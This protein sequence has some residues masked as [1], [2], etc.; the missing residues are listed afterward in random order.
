M[1]EVLAYKPRNNAAVIDTIGEA[2][3]D[4]AAIPL[5]NARAKIID[6]HSPAWI[7]KGY[8]K[9][10]AEMQPLMDAGARATADIVDAKLTTAHGKELVSLTE[11]MH[12]TVHH[13]RGAA[14]WRGVG[15]MAVLTVFIAG[16]VGYAV[17]A[18][19]TE[20]QMNAVAITQ[21]AT[22]PS[23]EAMRQALPPPDPA[24]RGFR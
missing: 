5:W 2:P 7:K 14:F 9:A 22:R 21:A 24:E 11:R 3:D 12:D 20:S 15:T 6:T 4:P 23:A 1:G 8:E 19:L 10:R 13:V 17:S 18:F 16:G